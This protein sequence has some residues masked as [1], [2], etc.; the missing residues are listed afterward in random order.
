[1]IRVL[2]S[3]QNV[4]LAPASLRG[5][6]I[7]SRTGERLLHASSSSNGIVVM[8]KVG[9]LDLKFSE[10]KTIPIPSILSW[11]ARKTDGGTSGK[12]GGQSIRNEEQ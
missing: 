12:A 6:F 9:E 5:S 7:Y 10:N 2:L 1:M 8:W 11:L 3:G 4:F